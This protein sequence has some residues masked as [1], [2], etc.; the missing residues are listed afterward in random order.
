MRKSLIS[1]NLTSHQPSHNLPSYHLPS[2]HLPSHNLPSHVVNGPK[3][4]SSFMIRMFEKLA[5]GV[6]DDM[7]DCETDHD[8]H[9]NFLLSHNLPSH[10]FHL[11]LPSHLV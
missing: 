1:H 5:F 3:I 10:S 8:H 9:H 7:V 4:N 2:S 6:M 11:N